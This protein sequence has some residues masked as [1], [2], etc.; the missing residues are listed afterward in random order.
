MERSNK[1]FAGVKDNLNAVTGGKSFVEFEAVPN[2]GSGNPPTYEAIRTAD[3]LYVE[4]A[5]GEREYYD[6]QSD[7][8]ELNNIIGSF[9]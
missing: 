4:Y 9:G 5:T 6:L 2:M 3:F 7:P 1:I 8:L